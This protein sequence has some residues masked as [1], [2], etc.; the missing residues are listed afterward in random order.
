MFPITPILHGRK[1][2]KTATTYSPPPSP[3][4]AKLSYLQSL[5]NICREEKGEQTVVPH[6]KHSLH[7]KLP[8][9]L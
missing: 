6:N 2:N 3:K 5:L 9:Q 1:K 7:N 8:W 4:S